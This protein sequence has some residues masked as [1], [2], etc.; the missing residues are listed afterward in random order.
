MQIE[1]KRNQQQIFE[2][3]KQEWRKGNMGLTTDG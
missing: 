3:E 1:Y 2:E